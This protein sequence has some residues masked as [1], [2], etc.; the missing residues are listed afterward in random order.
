MATTNKTTFDVKATISTEDGKFCIEKMDLDTITTSNLPRVIYLK[1][2]SDPEVPSISD[3]LTSVTEAT[4]ATAFTTIAPFNG[5][6]FNDLTNVG[7]ITSF[8][9]NLEVNSVFVR[10][11]NAS[12]TLPIFDNS[13]NI[14]VNKGK[15]YKTILSYNNI[16][17]RWD[18][19]GLY[20]PALDADFPYFRYLGFISNST[21]V[22]T[23][24]TGEISGHFLTGATD[25]PT[26]FIIRAI[27]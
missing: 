9:S 11:T 20:G 15:N 3:Y 13:T 22:P 23:L 19:Y 4:K 5:I 8:D 2:I 18:M 26:T 27:P 7:A 10:M 17:Q 25:T 16:K 14:Y 21:I 24:N 6:P 12:A 1:Y